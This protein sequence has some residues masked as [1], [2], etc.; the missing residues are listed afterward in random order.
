MLVK[1]EG[2]SFQREWETRVPGEKLSEQ[3]KNQ[4]LNPHMALV[5]NQT[6]ATLYEA[7]A[8]TTAPSLLP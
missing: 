4:Q 2:G 8:P 7:S 6:Q 3:D 5:R 1:F